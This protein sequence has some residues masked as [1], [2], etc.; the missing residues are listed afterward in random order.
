MEKVQDST[1]PKEQDSTYPLLL[2]RPVLSSKAVRS[3]LRS[4]IP[5]SLHLARMS[6]SGHPQEKAGS[7][8]LP[9][10]V[11]KGV[12]FLW[13]LGC[14]LSN[15]KCLRAHSSLFL[16]LRTK[17]LSP[18]KQPEKMFLRESGLGHKP[19][20]ELKSM[21]LAPEC[22]QKTR[23]LRPFKRR[24]GCHNDAMILS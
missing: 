9:N 2:S 13:Q 8:K 4:M 5:V 19:L 7:Q 16:F 14:T 20:T 11:K 22:A 17:H 18:L 10:V 12:R 21:F 3:P 24:F 15:R 1:L 23:L 6:T